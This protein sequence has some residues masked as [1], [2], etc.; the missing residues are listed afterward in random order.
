MPHWHHKLCCKSPVLLTS[1]HVL[2]T[3][4][5]E[6][7][8]EALPLMDMSISSALEVVWWQ[9]TCYTKFHFSPHWGSLH[10]SPKLPSCVQ[11]GEKRGH[12]REKGGAWMGMSPHLTHLNHWDEY[13][14][15]NWHWITCKLKLH[16]ERLTWVQCGHMHC[17]DYMYE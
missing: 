16:T 5:S 6:I 8:A 3:K 14:S 11:E 15:V 7:I 13:A 2:A 12:G 1:C 4:C 17:Q 9:Q 10:D